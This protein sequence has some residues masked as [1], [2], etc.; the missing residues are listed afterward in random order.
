MLEMNKVKINYFDK[1]KSWV[2]AGKPVNSLICGD[3][4]D[5]LFEFKENEIDILLTDPPY[6]INRLGL[7][8]GNCLAIVKN[9]KSFD[10][11]KIP[12]KKYFN[13][14]LRVTKNQIIFG[15]NYFTELVPAS[16]GWIVWDKENGNNNFSD[17]E[18][19]WT[20]FKKAI[21][22]IKYRWNGMLQENQKEKEFRV[23]PTQKPIKLIQWILNK[24]VESGSLIL[25][26]HSGSASIAIAC[27]TEGYDFIA[28]EKDVDYYNASVK[29][30][31]QYTE[32]GR[33]F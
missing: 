10:D 13:E 14:I 20:S 8:G 3:C 30:F 16:W 23:H 21:R 25:D 19:V 7:C 24:Y 32:Q 12:D 15:G 17:C 29:R 26:T 9:Y 22:K 2:E 27:W 33:L 28:I 18:L 11:S 4:M 31:K 5:L 6:G 1:I